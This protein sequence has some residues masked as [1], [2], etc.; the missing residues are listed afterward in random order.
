[1]IRICTSIPA[2][3]AVLVAALLSGAA[4]AQDA[5][6]LYLSPV[7]LIADSAGT[8]LYIAE[9]TAHRIAVF[10][11]ASKSVERE[12]PLAKPPTGLTLSPDGTRLY[13]TCG[14]PNGEVAVI[15]AA[16]GSQTMSIPA[17]HTPI[18]P[19]LSADGARLYFCNRFNNEVVAVDLASGQKVF[20]VPM[21]REPYA[22]ALT[23]DGHWLCVANHLPAGAADGDYTAATISIV[24]T[25]AGTEAARIALPNGCTGLRG[26]CVSPDG[27]YAYATHLLSR[28]H[29]PTTQLE[30]G[31]M[32]TNAL[33][34]VDIEKKELVNTVLLD[35]VD[36]GAANPWGVACSADGQWLCVAHAGT[37]ELSAID[38][39]ALHTKLDRVAAGERV[40]E[41]SQTKDDVPNDLAFLVDLRRRIPLKGNGPRGL[42]LI[43]TQAYAAEYFT[44]SVGTVSIA[45]APRVRAESL[46]L[47][48]ARELTVPRKGELFFNDAALCFQHWQSCASCHPDGRVDALNWDLMN[49]GLGNPKNTKNMLL[50]HATP[51][52]MTLGVRDTAEMAVRA[53]IK[54]IQFAVRPEEDA[55]AIDEY[56]KSMKP[57][58]SPYLAN[59]Q[60]SESAVR[61]QA[62]FERAACAECH[63]GPHYTDL[64]Q[65][66]VGT[67][68]GRD[69]GQLLD[70]PA[71]IEG[72]RTAP[73]LHDGRSATMEEVLTKHNPGD[74]HGKTSALSAEELRDLVAFLMSL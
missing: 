40:S 36:L 5:N 8:K 1:M 34:V 20:A 29:L 43:G 64:K 41:V 11:V 73:Y 6:P 70:T 22:A 49:D 63:N 44:D 16:S 60:L 58:P 3:F 19:V 74:M 59:G 55:I 21:P 51:P 62:V 12:I 53:G 52:A 4:A 10:D 71:L 69:I 33:S 65:Y 13:V 7:A 42:A 28:Y 45:P 68:S 66:D 57:E 30:R 72:W 67:A 26:I 39:P 14:G 48:P 24:D 38:R 2:L 61:G 50:A 18:S 32:N 15:E 17:G 56:M 47:G 9:Y 25:A 37:H 35:S 46:P 23:S 27:K 31:W 54:Y